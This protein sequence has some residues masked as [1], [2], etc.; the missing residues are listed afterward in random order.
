M[1]QQNPG[2]RIVSERRN[3]I[4]ET[5]Y[6][7][8]IVNRHDT[9]IGHW[10]AH[11]GGWEKD[12]IELL[13]WITSA[14]YGSEQ[15]VEILDIGANVG[16]HAIA[17]A[18]FP[19]PR[20]TVHAFEAQRI[21]FQMLAGTIALNALDNVYCH[22][23]AVSSSSGEVIEIAAIDYD[24][25]GDFGSLEL[26]PARNSDFVAKRIADSME[27]IRTVAID[28]L[29]LQSVRLMK[30]DTEGMEHKVLAGAVQ[31]LERSRPVLFFEYTK[32][33]FEWVRALL[34]HLEYRSYYAQR[35]NVLAFPAEFTDIELKGA[36]SVES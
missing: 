4:R 22:H 18:R 9:V 15:Q 6:G 10:I 19:F 26:E 36:Q 32:T 2:P 1:V 7:P 20:V 21:V 35:P 12:E 23:N 3:L 5:A 8:V 33:D 17:F 14:C 31:T 16:T 24:A 30:I 29:A 25:P 11:D 34:R 28:E 27:R 13:R